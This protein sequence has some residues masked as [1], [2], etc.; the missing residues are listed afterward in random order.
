MC[1]LAGLFDPQP[2]PPR[3]LAQAAG[4]MA[5][6]L[7]HRGP[8]DGGVWSDEA[9]GIGLGFRRLAIVDLS[10]LGHQPMSCASGRWTLV[11]N[12]EIYSWREI[13]AELEA[14]GR[15]FRS[16]SDTEVLVEAFDRWGVE[17][18]LPRLIGMFAIAAWDHQARRLWLVRDRLG[19]KPLYWGALPGGGVLFGSEL[20]AL[21][22]DPRCPREIDRDALAAYVRHGY[23]P[24]P[25]SI[26]KGVEKLQP[27]H[28]LTLG[29][30]QAP[31]IQCWWDLRTIAGAG[32]AA[33]PDPDL[34]AEIETLLTDAVGRRMVADVPLGAFLSGGIDSSLV[35]A[36]M[37][38]QSTRPVKSFSIGFAAAGYDEAPYAAQVAR[39]LGTDHTELYVSPEDALAVVPDLATW[40]DEPFADS[41]QI[42]TLLVSR[43]ARQHVTVA[44][45]GDGG[46][47]GFAGYARYGLAQGLWARLGRVPRVLRQGA[48][49]AIR[50]VPP[51]AYDRMARLLPAGLRPARC[52]DKAHKLAGVLG[53][54]DAGAL[55]RR[56]ISQWH[57]PAALVPGGREAHGPLWDP[58]LTREFPDLVTRLQWLDSVTY[59][60]D[61]ILTKVDRA[62][63][64]VSLEARVPLIDHRIIERVWRLP[65][66]ERLQNG[67]SKRLLRRVL[68][69]HVPP[70][71]FERPKMGFGVPIDSWLRGPLRDWAETLLA[72]ARLA[73]EG[74]FDPARVRSAWAEH[75]A[76]SRNR[77]YEIWV[78]LM[79]QAWLDRW[80]GGF[81]A[82]TGQDLPP[83][84]LAQ[85]PPT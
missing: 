49:G 35:V 16:Q 9:A 1:G 57:D 3:P 46:D 25:R 6:T 83:S 62:S 38:A 50:A 79:F 54:D 74:W 40:Y 59:L 81:A 64:A 75:L 22:A 8:D 34:A 51:A 78:V 66:S 77:Q 21:A 37:Q 36:L 69:R 60:P 70:A 56:L 10:P 11:Y 43:L 33:G 68:G 65:A 7:Y 27:G 42:P 85:V 19:I 80:G 73:G 24:G 20:K 12:G 5:A 4:A 61:D 30:G 44:L 13:R 76:G 55:Y 47:E 71:L 63:M 41:S 72:P 31:R 14:E 53:L 84:G 26:W 18:T 39:H 29:A 82:G 52:G 45:S 2:H 48:A 17:K 67:V 32:V 28:F 15:V 23:V 58:D